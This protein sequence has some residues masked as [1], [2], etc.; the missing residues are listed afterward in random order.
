LQARSAEPAATRSVANLQTPRFHGFPKQ[1]EVFLGN[2]VRRTQPDQRGALARFRMATPVVRGRPPSR[3]FRREARAFVALRRA[4][5]RAATPTMS[6]YRE[7]SFDTSL[8]QDA[9]AF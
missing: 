1:R 7:P 2:L 3:P 5:T 8:A 9:I 6:T 4:P